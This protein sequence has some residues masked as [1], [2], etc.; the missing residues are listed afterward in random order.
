[1]LSYSFIRDNGPLTAFMP[2][3]ISDQPEF[4]FEG[5]T[6]GTQYRFKVSRSNSIGMSEFSDSV[7]FFAA[8]EPSSTAN[9]RAVA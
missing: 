5:L 4:K 3:Q 9:F 8:I 7:A 1:M 2:A 6:A